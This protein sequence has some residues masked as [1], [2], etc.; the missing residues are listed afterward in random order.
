MNRE[1]VIRRLWV[2]I[3]AQGSQ[4]DAA[5]FLGISAQYLNDVIQGRRD[6]GPTLLKALGI[7]A[8]QTYEEAK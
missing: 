7:K 6:P 4:K 8:V 5:A 2:V 1:S 3:A